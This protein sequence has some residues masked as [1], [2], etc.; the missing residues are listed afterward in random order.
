[1]RRLLGSMAL[2]ALGFA[3]PAGAASPAYN[4]TG[5]YIG[6]NVGYGWGSASNILTFTDPSVTVPGAIP[7]SHSYDLNGVIGGGGVGYNFQF[8]SVVVGLEADISYTHLIGS[9]SSSRRVCAN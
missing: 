1:M 4:W 2:I 5:F 9:A 6:G 3:G 8:N 7:S